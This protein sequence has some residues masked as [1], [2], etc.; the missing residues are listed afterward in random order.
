MKIATLLLCLFCV[1]CT[2]SDVDE[3][4][5]FALVAIQDNVV[6]TDFSALV[7]ITS[8]SIKE[9][10]TTGSTMDNEKLLAVHYTARVLE[11][12]LGNKAN[13]IVFT[14]YIDKNEG[15]DNLSEG[16]VIVSLCKESDGTYYLP[17]IGYE[18]P[19]ETALIEKAREIKMLIIKK[20]LVL[21]R[22]EKNYACNISH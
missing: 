10:S 7:E 8:T 14:E 17:D 18:L 4:T 16:K 15:L 21:H 2:A 9:L 13:T 6:T 3:Q 20:K 19:P 22:D 12:F 5:N 11:S 1:S